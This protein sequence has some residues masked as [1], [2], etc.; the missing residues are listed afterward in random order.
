MSSLM[1]F[2]L[3][4]GFT[5]LMKPIGDIGSM[6]G[7][8]FPPP[9]TPPATMNPTPFR[10]PPH[11]LLPLA[12]KLV[13]VTAKPPGPVLWLIWLMLKSSSLFSV[14]VLSLLAARSPGLIRSSSLLAA[15]ST[16]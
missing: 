4:D 5:L 13:V 14:M 7:V 11:A 1:D 8:A 15:F 3:M 16:T 10:S 6:A 12:A 9:T 2:L